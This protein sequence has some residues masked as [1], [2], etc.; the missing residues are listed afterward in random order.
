M[1]KNT[2]QNTFSVSLGNNQDLSISTAINA[3]VNV[4]ELMTAI[5]FIA[6]NDKNRERIQTIRILA[7]IGEDFLNISIDT[8]SQLELRE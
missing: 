1:Q 2:Q 6:D 8:M 4:K 7:A 3:A 5:R